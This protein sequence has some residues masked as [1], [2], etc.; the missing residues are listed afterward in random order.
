MCKC[1]K[2]AIFAIFLLLGDALGG[3]I[4]QNVALMKRRLDACMYPSI[5]II[6]FQNIGGIGNTRRVMP[7][8]A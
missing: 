1:K 2:I 7:A 6:V 8:I 4:T 3:A 5:T